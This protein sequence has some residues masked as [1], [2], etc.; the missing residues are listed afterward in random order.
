MIKRLKSII[1]Q[2]GLVISL[3]G[4]GSVLQPFNINI[5]TSGFYILIFGAAL[6]FIGS[7]IPEDSR[8]MKGLLQVTLTLIILIAILVLTI[9][10]APSLVQ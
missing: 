1:E 4:I 10:L 7:L 2:V 5:Y 8:I 9:Y 3:L 6:Y